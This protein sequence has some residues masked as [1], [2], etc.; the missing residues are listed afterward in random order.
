MIFNSRVITCSF[1]FSCSFTLGFAKFVLHFERNV[2][3][4][5]HVA[6]DC[7]PSEVMFET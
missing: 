7:G 2:F 5:K 6:A 1:E 3:S 4:D